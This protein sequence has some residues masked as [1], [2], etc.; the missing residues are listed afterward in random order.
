MPAQ[1]LKPSVQCVYIEKQY[2]SS[3]VEWKNAFCVKSDKNK[4]DLQTHRFT[5]CQ[6]TSGLFVLQL[7]SLCIQG[8][9]PLFDEYV[10]PEFM[11]PYKS[12]CLC[13][14]KN[15]LLCKHA[16]LSQHYSRL[17]LPYFSRCVSLAPHLH[18]SCEVS[19][20]LIDFDVVLQTHR[21]PAKQ[22]VP[23]TQSK[24]LLMKMIPS[25]SYS[26][27]LFLFINQY[28]QMF[29]YR[30]VIVHP[31]PYDMQNGSGVLLTL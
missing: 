27:I 4:T 21:N 15:F 16:F 24:M 6:P 1:W 11:V 23:C 13:L 29:L 25:F 30:D 3:A 22:I 7:M 28:L 14:C 8:W 19:S 17:F 10:Y 2:K 26:F 12:M 31:Q 9:T 18:H 5:M 20:Y